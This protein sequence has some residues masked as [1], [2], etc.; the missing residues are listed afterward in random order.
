MQLNRVIP[1]LALAIA[2]LGALTGPAAAQA[3]RSEPALA[4]A[5][6][7]FQGC[8][9]AFDAGDTEEAV[10]SRLVTCMAALGTVESIY[11]EL[12]SPTVKDRSYRDIFR[13]SLAGSIF[14]TD[15][16]LKGGITRQGCTYARK[17][18]SIVSDA[19]IVDQ[20]RRE[21]LEANKAE[22]E[23]NIVP[24]CDEHYPE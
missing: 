23:A 11:A 8:E 1:A 6:E 17:M 24:V 7:A 2:A 19:E 4:S 21:Q 3:D 13:A 14:I 15:M 5:R 10:T 20:K 9:E 12:P 18:V 16:K 22:L